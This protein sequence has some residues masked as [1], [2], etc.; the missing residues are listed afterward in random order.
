MKNF[1][2]LNVWNQK[3]LDLLANEV[4][5]LKLKLSLSSFNESWKLFHKIV[6]Y[7]S[8]QMKQN[9]YPILSSNFTS[10]ETIIRIIVRPQNI[11]ID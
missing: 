3:S 5:I 10:L 11:Q 6:K 8:I 7:E 4:K 2:V 9:L 1:V